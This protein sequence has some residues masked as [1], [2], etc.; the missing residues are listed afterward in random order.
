[1]KFKI[2]DNQ[3]T[4]PANIKVIGVGGGGSNAVNLMVVSNIKGVQ[5]IAA[6]TDSDALKKS[7][8]EHKIQLGPKLTKGQG[9]GAKP[10]IGKQATE[11][12]ASTVEQILLGTDM[13]FITAGMGGGTGTGGAPVVA[14]VAKSLGILTVGIVTKP[15]MWE[16]KVK[17]AIAEEGI[18][19]LKAYTDALIEIPNQR[20]FSIIDEDTLATQTFEKANEVL[21]KAVQSISDVITSHGMI[22][23]DFQDVKTIMSNT[24]DAL[25]GFGEASGEDRATVAT[26]M[27]ITS[28]LLEDISIDG[29]K[30]VLVNITGNSQD[31]KMSEI[32][33]A[34][35]IIHS[36]VSPEAH[37]IYGQVYDDE[38]DNKFKI[39][40]IATG[41]LG[42]KKLIKQKRAEYTEEKKVNSFLPDKENLEIPAYKRIKVRKLR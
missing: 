19:E 29:A 9:S 23:V 3:Q 34:M 12:S 7:I 32:D 36:A 18:K 37:L 1:M 24:G 40:V 30:G 6:N 26:K 27:A 17:M 22:N 41:F 25:L 21:K 10:E 14:K 20:L 4:M 16:G 8:A 35:S 5:F 28:P 15:F 13:L 42:D 2:I 39:T 11:E 31:L 38:L 33:T